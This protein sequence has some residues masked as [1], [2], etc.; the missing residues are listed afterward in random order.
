[1]VKHTQTI[2]PL[3]L[4]NCLIAFDPFVGLGLKEFNKLHY[5]I[6]QNNTA[7]NY[8]TGYGVT[9]FLFPQFTDINTFSEFIV[10]QKSES[11][12][13]TLFFMRTRKP[14]VNAAT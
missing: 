11:S 8:F 3:L 5:K 6:P 4:T 12:Q 9:F 2:R 1:M 7:A 13:N 10:F 14:Q